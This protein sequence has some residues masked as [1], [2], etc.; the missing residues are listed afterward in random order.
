MKTL[1]ALH[2]RS[3]LRFLKICLSCFGIAGTAILASGLLKLGILNKDQQLDRAYRIA[4]PVSE[5]LKHIVERA[6]Y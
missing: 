3:A 2:Q 6:M 4:R 1:K 5:G